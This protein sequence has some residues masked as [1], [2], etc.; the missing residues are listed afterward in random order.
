[1]IITALPYEI[2]EKIMVNIKD[3]TR[4]N[5]VCTL[6]N[7][8]CK[9]QI[10]KDLRFQCICNTNIWNAMKCKS[11]KHHCICLN[12]LDSIHYA[13][14]CRALEHPCICSNGTSNHSTTCRSIIHNCICDI[15]MYHRMR[16]R[17][18]L[19]ITNL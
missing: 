3:D 5:L 14:K 1:M 19:H 7:E 12:D 16:C 18:T 10:I 8:I 13:L 4:L 6:W 9:K 15:D 2:Q 17:T 11:T